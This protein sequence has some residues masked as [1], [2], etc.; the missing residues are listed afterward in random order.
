MYMAAAGSQ[1]CK[2]QKHEKSWCYC[3]LRK[4]LYLAFINLKFVSVMDVAVLCYTCSNIVPGC[5][6]WMRGDS[7]ILELY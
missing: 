7:V 6:P 3:M 4:R 1:G 2:A 5:N